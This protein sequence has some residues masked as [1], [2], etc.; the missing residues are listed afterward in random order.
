MRGSRG[1][2]R[3]PQPQFS[4]DFDMDNPQRKQIEN[5]GHHLEH[6]SSNCVSANYERTRNHLLDIKDVVSYVA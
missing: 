5:E 2:F 3:T 1:W 4:L 6:I